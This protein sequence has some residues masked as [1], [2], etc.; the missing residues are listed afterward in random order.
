MNKEEINQIAKA[1]YEYKEKIEGEE[2]LERTRFNECYDIA[3]KKIRKEEGFWRFWFTTWEK[4][5][6][7][8]LKIYNKKYGELKDKGDIK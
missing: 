6:K 7:E 5:S 8:A 2:D 1:V 4:V 3:S